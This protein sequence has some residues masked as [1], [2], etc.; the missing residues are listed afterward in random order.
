MA[1]ITGV[2]AALNIGTADDEGVTAP[3]VDT[4]TAIGGVTSI[5]GPS[6]DKGETEVTDLADTAR[7]YLAILPDN[8]EVGFAFFHDETEA[9]QTTI[10][11][12]FN[13]GSTT[14]KRNYQITLSDGTVIDFKGYVKSM[15]YAGI[16][17]DEG[18]RVDG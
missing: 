1:K 18:V 2:G 10:W 7:D 13:D 4:F 6:G 16:G 14:H 5:S 15:S 9:T 12:D 8:G 17:L 3:G 11:G